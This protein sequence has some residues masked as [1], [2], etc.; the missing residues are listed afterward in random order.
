[1]NI[2]Q[3]L[4]YKN[5]LAKKI[6]ETAQKVSR[7]NSVDEG[8]VR[9]YDVSEE[10]SKLQT[11][12]MEMVDL[13]TKIHMANRDVYHYIFKLSEMKAMLKHLRT[14]DCTEGLNVSLSRFAESTST[15]KNSVISRLEMDQLIEKIEN[16]IDEIQDK[17]DIHNSTTYLD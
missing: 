13:K 11:L 15:M 5:K 3:A 14:V 17:L 16:Q 1:M 8:A 2:K 12:T 9:P 4:K 10:L 7:Y 6:S